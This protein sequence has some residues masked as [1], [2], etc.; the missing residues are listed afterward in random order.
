MEQPTLMQKKM[1]DLLIN[2]DTDVKTLKLVVVA[3]LWTGTQQEIEERIT[4]LEA[5]G[6]DAHDPDVRE[7]VERWSQ[8]ARSALDKFP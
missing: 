8:T 1:L 4:I 7:A 3:L 5:L 2:T 6:K